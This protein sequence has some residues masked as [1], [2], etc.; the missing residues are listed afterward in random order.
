MMRSREASIKWQAARLWVVLVGICL[1]S[2][3][4][5]LPHSRSVI[6]SDGP[7]KS[8]VD[9]SKVPNAVPKHERQTI[10]GNKSPY[11]VLGK[12]YRVNFDTEG[13]VQSGEASWYGTKFHGRKTSNGETYDMFAMTAAHKTLPIPCYVRVTNIQNNKSV[14]VRVN[15]RGP[16]H[17]G[18]IIDLSYVAAQKL[19]IV[20]HGVGRVRVEV[21]QPTGTPSSGSQKTLKLGNSENTYIQVGAFSQ[22]QG[23]VAHMNKVHRYTALPAKVIKSRHD[24]LYRVLLGP[25]S[26]Q[27]QLDQADKKLRSHQLSDFHLV[28]VE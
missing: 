8:S 1:G 19:D 13:F 9:I 11:T 17:G 23:A 24:Q 10:A 12:T 18:R 4:S 22:K 14:V 21:V 6:V 16:F 5:W 26:S 15:D 3:C 27:E 28:Q 25:V 2:G 20:K 7:P